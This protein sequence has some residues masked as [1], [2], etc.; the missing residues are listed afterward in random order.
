MIPICVTSGSILKIFCSLYSDRNLAEVII[1]LARAHRAQTENDLN[2]NYLANF[3]GFGQN[4]FG[5]GDL[6]TGVLKIV[7]FKLSI[8]LDKI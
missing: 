6:I 4:N 1:I 2:P 5:A 7:T 3:Q 8:S